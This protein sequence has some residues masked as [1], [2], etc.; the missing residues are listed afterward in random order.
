MTDKQANELKQLNVII[1][2]L[3][4]IPKE[5]RERIVRTVRVFFNMP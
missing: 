1:E 2:A 3:L 4:T 5:D